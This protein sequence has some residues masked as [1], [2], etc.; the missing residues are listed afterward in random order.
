LI[1]LKGDQQKGNWNIIARLQ[2]K[3]V[4]YGMAQIGYIS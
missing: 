2:K 4:V 3:D 1:I